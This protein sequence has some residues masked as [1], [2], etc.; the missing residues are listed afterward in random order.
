[1]TNAQQM[2]ALAMVFAVVAA[3]ILGWLISASVIGR[4][5]SKLGSFYLGNTVFECKAKATGESS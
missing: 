2:S 3:F 5:C 1:M 4:D